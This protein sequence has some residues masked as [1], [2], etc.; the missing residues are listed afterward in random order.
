MLKIGVFVW[1]TINWAILLQTSTKVYN[2]M[3]QV[4]HLKM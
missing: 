1:L 4:F 2:K 3:G